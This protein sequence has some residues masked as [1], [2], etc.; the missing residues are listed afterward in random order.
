[1]NE[2]S[3]EERAVGVPVETVE[4]EGED[5]EQE[6]KPLGAPPHQ[7][8][9]QAGSIQV[10]DF[11]EP[12]E[13]QGQGACLL[14]ASDHHDPDH[15]QGRCFHQHPAGAR[16]DRWPP[17]LPE[18]SPVRRRE[19]EQ[20]SEH[21]GSR[22]EDHEERDCHEHRRSMHC[23]RPVIGWQRL[24]RGSCQSAIFEEPDP[25]RSRTAPS[26]GSVVIV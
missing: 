2:G 10:V 17:A 8:R 7:E 18:V 11:P 4:N 21:D 26:T 15:E 22:D 5:D 1:M 23:T 20:D 19:E 16:R 14:S 3:S 9:E 25:I 6:G 12:Q 24:S 13:E